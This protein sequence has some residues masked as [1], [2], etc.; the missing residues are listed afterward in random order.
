MSID[1]AQ[2]RIS[3]VCRHC[4]LSC[5]VHAQPVVNALTRSLKSTARSRAVQILM[6]KMEFDS[7]MDSIRVVCCPKH[8]AQTSHSYCPN[9]C[10][11][12][13]L[14]LKHLLPKLFAADMSDNW[15]WHPGVFPVL[16]LLSN[17]LQ[18]FLLV[19]R[20]EEHPA[21]KKL[22]DEG[23]SWLSVWSKVQTICIWF[24]WCHCHPIV[25]CFIKIQIGLAW[26]VSVTQ[27]V[28][29]NRS[30]KG[31]KWVG[32]NIPLNTL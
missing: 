17:Y 21:C 4:H 6:I 1:Y 31:V 24:S 13:G 19:M 20:Q 25:P 32:F 27:V 7:A 30:L 23:Q 5:C 15:W 26:L 22:S 9:A 16:L 8:V 11:L 10:H 18:C 12:S 3:A 28:L 29:E 2:A 14:S